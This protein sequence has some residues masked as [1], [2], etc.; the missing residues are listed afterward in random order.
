VSHIEGLDIEKLVPNLI[1]R[2]IT[3]SSAKM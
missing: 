1:Q 3:Y 2:R